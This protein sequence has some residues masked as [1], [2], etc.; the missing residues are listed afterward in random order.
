MAPS[1][2]G[3]LPAARTR[4]DKFDDLIGYDLATFR[5]HLGSK[6]KHLDFGVLDVPETDPAPWEHGVPLARY[7]PFERP[8]KITGRIV[9]YRLPILQ[10]AKRAPL[11]RTCS[12]MTLSPNSSPPR[13][14][15]TPRKLTISAGPS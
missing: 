10:A 4:A 13:W 12:S 15:E 3:H 9:F 8:A 5:A 2:T 1:L 11:I 14:A 7:L 6:M